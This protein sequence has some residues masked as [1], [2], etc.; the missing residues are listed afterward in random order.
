MPDGLE[1]DFYEFLFSPRQ[2]AL[3]KVDEAIDRMEPST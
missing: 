1:R 2:E 3:L